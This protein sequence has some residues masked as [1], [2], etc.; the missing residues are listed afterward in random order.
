MLEAG[1]EL[2]ASGRAGGGTILVGGDEGGQ[3]ELRR[4]SATYVDRD[5]VLRADALRVGD[6]ELATRTIA[7][8]AVPLL[9]L[10][11]DSPEAEQAYF[12]GVT[13]LVLKRR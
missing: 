2:D 8:V 4:S 3:G 10:Y 1:A 13:S 5:A 7:K 12:K 6:A 9:Q 11:G